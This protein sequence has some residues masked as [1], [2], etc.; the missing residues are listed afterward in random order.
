MRLNQLYQRKYKKQINNKKI[1]NKN[2]EILKNNNKLN[3]ILK[4]K[5]RQIKK[6]HLNNFSIKHVIYLLYILQ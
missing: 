6:Y 2:K 5:K 1:R 4:R 3:K